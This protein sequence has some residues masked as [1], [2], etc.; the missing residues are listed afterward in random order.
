MDYSKALAYL[1]EHTN[2]EK[3]PAVAGRVEGLSL[4]T[5]QRLMHVLGDP[6]R[7]YRVVHITGTNG[8]GSV[9]RMVSAL[10]REHGLSVGTYASPHLQRLNERLAWD[11]EPVADDE[12]GRVMA[13]IADAEV[14]AGVRPSYFELLT[15]AALSWFAEIAVDVAVVEVG[16]LGR[17]DATNVVDADV[18][19]VTNIGSDHTDGQGDWRR[20]IASEK[21]GIVAPGSVLVLGEPDPALR[22][23]FEAEAPL[24]MFVRGD[25]FDVDRELPAVGGRLLDVR[26]PAAELPELFL[27]LYGR[28]QA[29]NAAI[30]LTAT[31]AFFGRPLDDEVVQQA[32]SSVTVPGR[33]EVVGR[34]PLIVLDSAHNPDGAAATAETFHDEFDVVGR[35]MLVMGMLAGRDPVQ[36]LEALEVRRADV[37]L[38]CTAPSP[39]AVPADDLAAAARALGVEAEAV[40]DVVEA[41]ERALVVSTEDDAVLVTGSM[42]VA[43]A[44]RTALGIG[45]PEGRGHA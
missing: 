42:Y 28:H 18:A 31:E 23:V 43:G 13:S 8:K 29:D 41:I 7:A 17:Y 34:N 25:D 24:A 35:R 12:L 38:T 20:A 39:R 9:A 1:D 36:L 27:P 16:L 3:D 44:A 45:S 33:F 15:S 4:E 32:L 2:L 37:V 30:A 22:P 40:P 5:M 21:A 10:L 26:T 14:V 11:L 19:V 6:H